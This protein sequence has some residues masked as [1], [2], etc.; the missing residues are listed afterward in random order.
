CC[1]SCDMPVL[2]RSLPA[3]VSLL[4]LALAAPI[5]QAHRPGP[6]IL[7]APPARAPQLQNAAPWQAPPI[8]V[9]GAQAYRD[10]EWLYQDFLFDDHGALGVPDPNTPWDEGSFTFS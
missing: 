6:D 10:G 9:S 3:V 4:A 5:A 8:L 2:R 7:Y 1:V